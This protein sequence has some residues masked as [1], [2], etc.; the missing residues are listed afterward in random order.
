MTDRAENCCLN[1]EEDIWL[2]NEHTPIGSGD[3]SV[4][5][6]PED[7]FMYFHDNSREASGASHPNFSSSATT[8]AVLMEVAIQLCINK[9][10]NNIL[11]FLSEVSDKITGNT[12]SSLVHD[13]HKMLD[14]IQSIDI[15]KYSRSS[16]AKFKLST[17]PLLFRAP[18]TNK[19]NKNY[20][21]ILYSKEVGIW[22]VNLKSS[23]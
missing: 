3:N 19:T 23:W 5:S 14:P 11:K 16:G 18:S 21:P 2:I 10:E 17:P 22:N 12:L 13:N 20:S 6:T 15:Y 8:A 9:M 4:T 1:L 7:P